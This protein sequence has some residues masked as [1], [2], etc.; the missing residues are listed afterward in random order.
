MNLPSLPSLPSIPAISTA[1]EVDPVC[2]MSVDP[3]TAAARLEHEGHAYFF[4]ARSCAAKFH[5]DPGKYLAPASDS[6]EGHAHAT[7]GAEGAVYTCPMHPEIE[8]IGPGTCPLCGMALEPKTL[9]LEETGPDPELVSMTRRFRVSAPLTLALLALTMGPML[10]GRHAFLPHALEGWVELLLALPVVLWG[11]APFFERGWQ[12][13]RHKSPNMFTLIALGTGAAF[14]ASLAAVLA[15][16][17][18]PESFRKGGLLPLYFEAAAVI[19]TLVQLGQILELRA[20]G[21]TQDALRALLALSPKTA[22]LVDS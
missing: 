18:F 6:H 16:G 5:A 20:R 21:R 8:Q 19:T 13:I 1:T 11:G 4:C 2:G 15:P 17:L 10:V 3:E 12:S 14:L 9:T 7:D 22:R